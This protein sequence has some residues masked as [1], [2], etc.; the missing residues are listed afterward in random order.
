MLT[1]I[2]FVFAIALLVTIHELGHYWVAR[3]C[4]VKILVFSIG[5]GKPLLQW[6]RGETLWQ[7]AA[8]PLGGY[9]KMLGEEDEDVAPADLPR[10][11]SRQHPLKRMAIVVAGPL[12]NFLLAWVLYAAAYGW[13]VQ[14][15]R[16]VIGSVTAGSVAE[17]AGVR[18]GD[19]VLALGGRAI[20]G[21]DSLRLVFLQLPAD[22]QQA[23][24]RVRSAG[25]GES[26]HDLDLSGLDVAAR[27]NLQIAQR[28][29]LSPWV[30]MRTVESV[31][32]NSPAGQAGFLP[33]DQILTIADVPVRVWGDFQAK[34]AAN[35][36][37]T[38]PIRVLRQ[39]REIELLATPTAVKEEGRLIGR[40]GIS[41]AVD[42]ERAKQ[43]RFTL[44]LDPIEALQRGAR[45]VIDLS[46][47]TVKLFVRMLTG[48][49][50]AREVSG[51]IGIARSA[52]QTAALGVAPYL[53]FLALV[54]LSLGVLNLLPV[55]VLDGGHLLY[56]VAELVRGRP[57]PQWL[58][59]A[60]QR[61][62]LGLLLALMALAFFND[63]Y[64]LISG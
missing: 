62:G 32:A 4:G 8:I 35:P 28:L 16:P 19:E 14:L 23:S 42:V 56:H 6:R 11:F 26:S 63:V 36:G 38:L 10:A 58:Q 34:V 20:D 64:R 29:G 55:P 15:L 13:G 61:L 49:F 53:Q 31:A 48:A 3:R 44:Q 39:G 51:P 52:G 41:P 24:L 43:A 57:L 12:A 22:L 54:S 1:L 37:V 18:A 47:L 60:G 9:V 5:F 30:L 21:W 25:G 45:D 46:G 27:A 59:L 40:L 7:I 2:S 33:G 17:R 50:S